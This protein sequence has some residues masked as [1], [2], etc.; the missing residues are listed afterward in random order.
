MVALLFKIQRIKINKKSKPTG[1]LSIVGH[2]PLPVH[3]FCQLLRTHDSIRIV[4]E[5][6]DSFNWSSCVGGLIS[7][8][9]HRFSF[10]FLHFLCYLRLWCI[11]TSSLFYALAK[12]YFIDGEIQVLRT[13]ST[14]IFTFRI[15]A[16]SLMLI[17]K[18]RHSFALN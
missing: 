12:L 6:I 7:E 14:L 13:Q 11:F 17:R 4:I 5:P 1:N 9:F 16:S 2:Q 15:Q 3:E 18:Y 8:V 10:L